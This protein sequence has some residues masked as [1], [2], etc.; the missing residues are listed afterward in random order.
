LDING[1]VVDTIHN[2][3]LYAG[4]HSFVWNGD[5]FSSGVYYF[6]LKMKDEVAVQKAVLVK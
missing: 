1:K 5:R 6:Q 4:E 3:N 2:G